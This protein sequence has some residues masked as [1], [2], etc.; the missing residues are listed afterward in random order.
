MGKVGF[1]NDNQEGNADKNNVIT[2]SRWKIGHE[3]IGYA[4][5]K[6]ASTEH[7]AISHKGKDPEEGHEAEEPK[8]K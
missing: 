7:P 8:E 2:L 6:E 4:S 3:V 5:K 1:K